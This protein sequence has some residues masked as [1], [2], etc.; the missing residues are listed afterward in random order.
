MTIRL[1]LYIDDTVGAH[2]AHEWD[3]DGHAIDSA[4]IHHRILLPALR[5]IVNRVAEQLKLAEQAK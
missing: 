4:E 3:L 1:A 2:I 5:A